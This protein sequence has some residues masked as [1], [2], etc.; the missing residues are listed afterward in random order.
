MQAIDR[1]I[2]D[3]QRA[4]QQNR[5]DLNVLLGLDQSAQVRLTGDFVL[6][7]L[8][9]LAIKAQLVH[10]LNRRPDIAALRAGYAAQDASYRAAIWA[11]FPLLNVGVTR[12]QDNYGDN[13]VGPG[14][15]LSL[16]IFNRNRGNIAI[17]RASRA[18]LYAD[19]QARWLAA[20]SEVGVALA[21]LPLLQAQLSQLQQGLPALRKQ[22][23]AAASASGSGNLS[24]PDATR[25]QLAWLDKQSELINLQ[26][27]LAEQQVALQ[28]LL[29]PSL[30]EQE[31][32]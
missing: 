1:Q 29:G 12:A 19:Y 7:Q 6:P 22:A 11:Q 18:Q 21:N 23:Q 5:A 31:K 16:P 3:Q 28:T 15:T 4:L 20:Q 27:M 10:R 13:S 32:P 25:M 2:N 8:D 30:P 24:A 9:I 17:A 14:V 26:Q